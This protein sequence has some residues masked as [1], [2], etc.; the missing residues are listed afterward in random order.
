VRANVGDGKLKRFEA[1]DDTKY[2]GDAIKTVLKEATKGRASS[3]LRR[4]KITIYVDREGSKHGK[5]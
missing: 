1:I 5:S 2:M 3:D 4:A